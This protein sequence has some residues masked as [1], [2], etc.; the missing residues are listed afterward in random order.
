MHL[1]PSDAVPWAQDCSSSSIVQ[2]IVTKSHVI[3]II[4]AHI[5]VHPLPACALL[6]MFLNLRT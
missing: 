2:Q 1:Y 6:G 3:G 5:A 4:S